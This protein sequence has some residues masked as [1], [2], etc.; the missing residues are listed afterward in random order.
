MQLRKPNMRYK[1]KR[2]V[3]KARLA[4]YWCNLFAARRFFQKVYGVDPVHEQFDQKGCYLNSPGSKSASTLEIPGRS[5]VPLLENHAQTRER[6]TFMTSAISDLKRMGRH[7]SLRAM[8]LGVCFGC[9][10]AIRFLACV[11]ATCGC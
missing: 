2:S 6:M 11:K 5:I 9:N 8:L 4:I 10:L 7:V 3:K 1:V